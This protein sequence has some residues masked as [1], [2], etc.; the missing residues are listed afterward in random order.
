MHLSRNKLFFFILCAQLISLLACAGMRDRMRANNARHA[1]IMSQTANHVYASDCV[2][3]LPDVR[4]LL[5]AQGYSVKSTD[6]ST[7]TVET[8]WLGMTDSNG[9]TTEKRYLVQGRQTQDASCALELLASTNSPSGVSSTRDL[10]T[11][12]T[13]LQS[14]EPQSAQRIQQ[15]ADQIYYANGGR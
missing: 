15:E 3:V 11:E 7:L 13:L 9:A 2:Q 8:E 6:P 12:W 1:H 10:E 5:F 4:R 14:I